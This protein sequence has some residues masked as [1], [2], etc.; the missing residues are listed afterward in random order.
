[1]TITTTSTALILLLINAYVVL[2]V[3][4]VV[5]PKLYLIHLQQLVIRKQFV[6]LHLHQLSI[7]KLVLVVADVNVFLVFE[8]NFL[9]LCW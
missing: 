5:Q 2:A 3:F 1:M 8:V 4:V 9:L 6:Q 7:L